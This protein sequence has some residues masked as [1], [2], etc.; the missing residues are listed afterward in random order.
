MVKGWFAY[1]VV[2]MDLYSQKVLSFEI[3]NTMDE[4]MCIKAAEKALS[5]YGVAA[6]IHTD[7]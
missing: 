2:I 6:M 7:M 4:H 3:S 1:G 5:K